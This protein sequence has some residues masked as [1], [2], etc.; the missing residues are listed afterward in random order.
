[1]LLELP[2]NVPPVDITRTADGS[3]LIFGKQQSYEPSRMPLSSAKP[4]ETLQQRPK[5]IGPVRGRRD[6]AACVATA[7]GSPLPA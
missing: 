6:T 2:V 7:R 3:A 1:V 5:R 4:P